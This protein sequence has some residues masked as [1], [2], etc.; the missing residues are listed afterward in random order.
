MEDFKDFSF[1]YFSFDKLNLRKTELR[2][3][4]VQTSGIAWKTKLRFLKVRNSFLKCFKC[5][6]VPEDTA[7]LQP[8]PILSNIRYPMS[9]KSPSRLEFSIFFEIIP[10]HRSFVTFSNK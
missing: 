1:L 9:L 3:K 8:G 6:K 10:P 5:Q 2:K 4:P 7:P